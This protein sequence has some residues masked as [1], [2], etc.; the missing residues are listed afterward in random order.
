M[1]VYS[2]LMTVLIFVLTSLDL[3]CVPAEVDTGWLVIDARAIVH[4]AHSFLTTVF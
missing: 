1:S 3:I 4:A 2:T